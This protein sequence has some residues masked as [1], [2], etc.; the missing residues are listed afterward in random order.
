MLDEDARQRVRALNGFGILGIRCQ[1]LSICCSMCA[2][3]TR[4]QVKACMIFPP[5]F[6][7]PAV[8]H[9][10]PMARRDRFLDHRTR[11]ECARSDA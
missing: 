5:L 1:T 6:V 3:A 8:L 10:R 11:T 4:V 2:V 9:S 7:A